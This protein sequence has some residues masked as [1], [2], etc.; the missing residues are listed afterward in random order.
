MVSLEFALDCVNL[1]LTL[2]L[3]G[4]LFL[5]LGSGCGT[6]F[7]LGCGEESQR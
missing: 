4:P 5:H 3:S 7:L 6:P 1:D 2:K